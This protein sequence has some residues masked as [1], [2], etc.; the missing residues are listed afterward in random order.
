MN[1]DNT[2]TV[3][4]TV[5]D[6]SISDVTIDTIDITSIMPDGAYDIN[7]NN[8]SITDTIRSTLRDSGTI[9]IDIWAKIYNNN[10]LE[11]DSY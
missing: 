5:H 10:K 9:P 8:I 3:T 11:D 2:I 6:V 4:S 7:W 1:S